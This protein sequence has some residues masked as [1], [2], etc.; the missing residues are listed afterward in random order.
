MAGRWQFT[1][2]A[3]VQGEPDTV[4]GIVIVRATQ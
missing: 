1:V 3:K 4:T 2:A